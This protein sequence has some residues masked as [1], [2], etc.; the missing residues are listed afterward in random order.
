MFL[1]LPQ[2]YILA[3]KRAKSYRIEL[4]FQ[5]FLFQGVK[6]DLNSQLICH[7]TKELNILYLKALLV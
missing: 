2:I 1:S 5:D 4:V 7:E 6:L 3:K